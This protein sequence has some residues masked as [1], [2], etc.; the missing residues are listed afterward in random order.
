[1]LYVTLIKSFK[2]LFSCTYIEAAAVYAVNTAIDSDDWE[3]CYEMLKHADLAITGLTIECASTY[4]E[5][6]QME[7][8][9]KVEEG[10][11]NVV[12]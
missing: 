9:N 3:T 4:H 6:L 7:K 1:M 5:G 10:F 12:I 8:Q 2:Y 11:C